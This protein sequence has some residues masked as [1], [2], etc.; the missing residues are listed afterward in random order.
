MCR[1]AFHTGYMPHG[2]LRLSKSQLDGACLDSRFDQARA[3]SFLFDVCMCTLQS[4]PNNDRETDAGP[5]FPI[6]NV[7]HPTY[8]I[9]SMY[10]KY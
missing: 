3:Q 7:V 9:L 1:A 4:P 10:K 6:H 2:I 5:P 8:S